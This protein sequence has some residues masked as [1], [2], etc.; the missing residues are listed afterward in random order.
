MAKPIRAT[1]TLKGEEAKN[2]IKEVLQEQ[3]NPSK[4]RV[5]LIIDAGKI[6]FNY[7]ELAAHQYT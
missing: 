7:S 3:K 4:A 5:K 1:P 6:K 2:F